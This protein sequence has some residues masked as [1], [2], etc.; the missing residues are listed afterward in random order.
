[1]TLIHQLEC[2]ARHLN[3]DLRWRV[4]RLMCGRLAWLRGVCTKFGGLLGKPHP[5][6]MKGIYEMRLESIWTSSIRSTLRTSS[7]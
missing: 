2:G 6:V 7:A 3:A 4:G 5:H 1:M